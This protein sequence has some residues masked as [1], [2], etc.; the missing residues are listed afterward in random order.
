MARWPV[1]RPTRIR[2]SAAEHDEG[3]ASGCRDVGA[4]WALGR[5]AGIGHATAEPAAGDAVQAAQLGRACLAHRAEQDRRAGRPAAQG[6][7]ALRQK[8]RV[9]RAKSARPIE[10]GSH[11]D[12]VDRLAQQGVHEPVFRLRACRAERTT[13]AREVL[14]EPH[15]GDVL[16]G[17]VGAQGRRSSGGHGAE[18]YHLRFSVAERARFPRSHRGAL[19]GHMRGKQIAAVAGFGVAIVGLLVLGYGILRM[20]ATGDTECVGD[21]CLDDLWFLAFP[22]GIMAMTAGLIIGSWALSAIRA[23]RGASGPF[24]VFGT[25]TGLG[26]VFLVMGVFFGIGYSQAGEAADGTFLFLGILFGV[27]GLCFIG[28]DL[29]RFRGELKTDRLRVSGLHGT[30]KVVAVHDSNVTVNNS[31][32]VS[33]DLDVTVPGQPPFRV[34]K[35]TVISRLS[36]GALLPGAVV[37]VLADPANPRD[38]VIDWDG[39]VTNDG[40]AAGASAA[41]AI[42]AFTSG[43]AWNVG[44]ASG[45]AP[46]S[47][48]ANAAILRSVSAALAQAAEERNTATS[49][50]RTCQTGRRW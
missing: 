18:P 23:E 1:P 43:G 34:R 49:G 3:R 48:P 13:V 16:R 26:A 25:M 24:R 29:L 5:P 20:S 38:I 41:D 45:L 35:R 40:S 14:G 2:Q 46:A 6:A 7:F 39:G 19:G 31:P 28:I 50:R 8:A 9:A 47:W 4:E 10:P 32:M 15:L 11:L 12:V 44:G 27:L 30:A 33:F 22:V 17:Q 21:E 42:R 37:P 36:V